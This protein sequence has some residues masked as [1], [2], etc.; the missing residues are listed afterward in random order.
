LRESAGVSGAG[1]YTI[2]MDFKPHRLPDYPDQ[3]LLDELR[4]AG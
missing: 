4:R 3:A 2:N 1:A